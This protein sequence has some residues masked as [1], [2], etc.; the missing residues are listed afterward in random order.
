[1][2]SDT[3]DALRNMIDYLKESERKSWEESDKDTNHIYND[4]LVVEAWLDSDN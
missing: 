2:D 3:I 4:A 1:M